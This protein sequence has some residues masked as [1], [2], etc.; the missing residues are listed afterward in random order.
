EAANLITTTKTHQ[1][2]DEFISGKETKDQYN[3]LESINKFILAYKY[4]KRRFYTRLGRTSTYKNSP[5]Q[6]KAE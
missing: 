3:G 2:N 6:R 5:H 1:Q 4:Y